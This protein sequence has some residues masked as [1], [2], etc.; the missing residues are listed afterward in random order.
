[1]RIRKK[2]QTSEIDFHEKISTQIWF[3]S[4]KEKGLRKKNVKSLAI[5]L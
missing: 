5:S 1:M 3:G 4:E 2:K